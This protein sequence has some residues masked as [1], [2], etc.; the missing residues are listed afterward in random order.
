[1]NPKSISAE[2]TLSLRSQVL[3]PGKP[4]SQCIFEEDTKPSTFHLGFFKNQELRGIVSMMPI[5]NPLFPEFNQ[6]QLRGMAVLPVA[7]GKG[8]GKKLLLQAEETVREKTVFCIIW[9]NV[10]EQAVAFYKKNDYCIVGD[11][12]EI[13][14]VG[15][16]IVMYKQIA[17]NS[18]AKTTSNS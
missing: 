12:F 13:P 18:P 7:Q 6:Y 2:E 3:R 4:I 17:Q 5:K 10:R 15:T 11:Y 16:H 8:I 14:A 9:C 1:M